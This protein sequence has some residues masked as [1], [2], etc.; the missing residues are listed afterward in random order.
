MSELFYTLRLERTG[1]KLKRAS[2]TDSG[3]SQAVAG[4]PVVGGSLDLC[5]FSQGGCDS[6]FCDR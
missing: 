5:A 2:C 3:A 6:W 1:I 4:T